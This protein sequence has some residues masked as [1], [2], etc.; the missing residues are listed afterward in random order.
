MEFHALD[1]MGP[2]LLTP[3][4]LSDKR[5]YFM[6]TFRQS[7]FEA[8]CGKYQFVQ[9]NQSKSAQ[10]VLRG[11]HYQLNHPQGKL[12]RVFKGQIVDVVVD[13]RQFSPNF[14]KYYL[15]PLDDEKCQSLWIP[16]GYAHGFYVKSPV[17]E[18]VYKCTAY[19]DPGDEYCIIWDDPDLNI[20]WPTTDQPIL[21]DKDLRGRHFKEAAIYT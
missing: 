4:I 19:Y 9:D 7:D 14:G 20:P 2:V 11:L 8:H 17:A 21:S 3:H 13:L 18:F 6:E 5:G 1:P 15:V 16:P 12:V 10:H